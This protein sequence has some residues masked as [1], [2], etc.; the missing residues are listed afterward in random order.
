VDDQDPRLF[1]Q[2]AS[3]VR[4]RIESG[5]LAAGDPVKITELQERWKDDD[6][7]PPARETVAHALRVLEAEGLIKRWPGVGYHVTSAG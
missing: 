2:I 1:A 7:K 5:E 3:D 6:G 4:E